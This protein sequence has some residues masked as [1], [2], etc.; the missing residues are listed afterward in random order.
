MAKKLRFL[1]TLLFVMAASFVW[2]DKVKYT[3]ASTSSVTVSGTAPQG[4]SATYSST[5]GTKYQ[6]T[7]NNSMTL[8]LKGFN[9]CTISNLTLRMKSNVSGGQGYLYY[10][11]G[12]NTTYIVGSSSG[13]K[14]FNTSDWYG[15]WSTSYVDISKNV[16]I[17][18]TSTELKIVLGA[19]ASSIYC[20]SFEITYS[21]SATPSKTDIAT[22]NSISPTELQKDATGTFTLDATFADGVTEDDYVISWAS[23]NTDVLSFSGSTYTA[24]AAGTANVTVTVT[25]TD[26]ES[27][28]AV[29]ETFAVTVIDPNA[30]GMVNNPYTVAQARA[31]ID[32]N[33]GLTDV[34]VKGIVSEIVTAFNSQYGNIS[35]NISDDGTTISDQLQ[36][37]R[38]KSYN[39]ANF[40]SADD[41]QVAD[42][43]VLF[44]TLKKYINNN[45]TTYEL[46]ANNQLVSLNRIEKQD[47]G[48]AYAAQNFNAVRGEGFTAP[49]LTNPNNLEVTYSSSNES[50]ATVDAA[51]GE[52]TLL[53][54][55]ET[56]ITAS[57]AG[58]K[59][60]NPGSASY[61]LTVTVPS[62]TVVFYENGVKLSET[63]VDEDE[64]IVFPTAKDEILG[65]HFVGWVIGEIEGT[66]DV[67]TPI[68]AATMGNAD[69]NYYAVYANKIAGEAGTILL[70][71]N[72]IKSNASGK[73]SYSN[74]YNIEGWTGRY[75]ISNSSGVY[76]LQLGYNTDP[77]KSAYNS[78]LTTPNC[79]GN[80]TSVTI[81]TQNNTAS[82]R[83]FYLCDNNDLGTA[84]ESNANYGKGS[85]ETAN[86]SVT[87]VPTGNTNIL[88]IY[89]N[90]T[91]YLK[92]ISL[93]YS[94]TTYS[95][96]C[97]TVSLPT[98]DVAAPIVFHDSGEYEAGLSV[99]MYAQAGA[100]IYYTTNGSEP[101]TAST[102][103]TGALTIENATTVKAIAVLD[104]VASAVVTREYTIKAPAAEIEAID[105]YYSIK[106][107]GNEKYINVA[108]RKTVTFVADGDE[109][110][111]AGTVIKVKATNGK[112]EVLRSQGVDLPGY[113]KKAMNYVP[114]IVELVVN[115]LHAADSGEILGPNGFKKIM[116]KFNKSF[117]Y[118]LYLEKAGEGYRIYGKT[119]SMK[120]V[121]DF[122]AENKADVDFKLP[123]LEDF[124]NRAIRK[125]LEK[126]NGHGASI[127]TDFSLHE[128]W[129]KMGSTLTEPVD[130]ASTAKF[131]EEVLSSE[132]NVWNFA[133][134]TAMKY[135]EPLIK[136][137]KVKD[138][139][140]KL[141]DYAKYLEKVENIQPD[142]KYYIVG[143]TSG[144]GVDFISQGNADI[145]AARATWTLDPRTDFKV[146]FNKEN[147]I[148]L[149]RELY[150]TLYTDFAYT[151]PE[152][153]KAYKVTAIDEKTGL[154][155]KEEITGV[156]P[157]QTPVLL[158]MIV[159]P[160][161]VT[162]ADLTQAL[163]LSTEAGTAVTGNLLQGP[164]ALINAFNIKTAQVV[165]LFDMAKEFLG[166]SAYNTY[167]KEYEHLQM[168]NAGTV[169][170]KYFF[171]IGTAEDTENKI[172]SAGTTLRTLFKGDKKLGFYLPQDVV[173]ANT[174]FILDE[175]NPV[176]LSLV[177]DVT[178][179][180][181]VNISDVTAQIDIILG[182]DT[183]EDNY[184][185]DAADVDGNGVIKIK[186][187]TD[188]IDIILGKNKTE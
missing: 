98:G 110:D 30:P 75:L 56:T 65:K 135:W 72:T 16:N 104:G 149:G 91:A 54:A 47:A 27:Y 66:T 113:A 146:T 3:V 159:D 137:D 48:L 101:T 55:G 184:D 155:T 145:N 143:N 15:S 62:R 119:P 99:P 79:V 158:Q 39:G 173:K 34:Y 37:Y 131:Y 35:Y 33:A 100:K 69:V 40:T 160:K 77:T 57:F 74:D 186:D 81:E 5:Y 151:V 36:S 59:N 170:N 180:G 134:Q 20:Q 176:L 45:V 95:D 175:T 182:K 174:A 68:T 12:N 129:Q 112:V 28:N 125:V 86:G 185:Y 121:V 122:Y 25:P 71:N 117:D 90:G 124:I 84:G 130:E 132:A 165:S 109:A 139:L 156:I 10:T 21:N 88:H 50:V 97:T 53:K 147:S 181:K 32:S 29:S 89:P 183:P 52:V 103:Y 126:T 128:I 154:A 108:G 14:G 167:V 118:N 87:I 73:N 93:N 11:Q 60:Y 64:P 140:D 41:I 114:E 70:D 148:N 8:T 44:G 106:N 13:G 78:H 172:Y 19:S 162:D 51:T 38:G 46:D 18:C 169:N 92:S 96:Y 178:R 7:K 6:L 142:F 82:G 152:K 42:E 188:L 24:N 111:K 26:T 171:G 138:N 153:V 23:D 94:T 22:L 150:T 157:A 123:Q 107:N 9:G 61:T 76:S 133:Y 141:G 58:N 161:T 120:P 49:S 187:V 105:G 115:K 168:K 179:D 4:S 80:I 136:H 102:E 166:E 85:I 164:D 177:G 17:E 1:F 31:A 67:C 116:D 63:E 2:A 127:L 43:V 83:T 163:T 144:N